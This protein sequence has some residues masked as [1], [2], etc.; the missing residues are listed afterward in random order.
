MLYYAERRYALMLPR[1]HADTSRYAI[2]AM[3]LI[4]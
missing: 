3:P 1:R 4:F 2:F